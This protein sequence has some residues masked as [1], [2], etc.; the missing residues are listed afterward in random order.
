MPIKTVSVDV[1]VE[2]D[3]DDFDDGDILDEVHARGLD[4]EFEDENL[5]VV[6][7]SLNTIWEK[8]RLG[9]DYDQDLDDLIYF[10]IGKI[11]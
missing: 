10:T 3:L 1:E 6:K 9:Q 8:K 2:I 5:E 7:A 4:V 11:L